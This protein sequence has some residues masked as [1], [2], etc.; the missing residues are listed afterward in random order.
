MTVLSAQRRQ[1]SNLTSVLADTTEHRTSLA[2]LT[3]RRHPTIRYEDHPVPTW[4]FLPDH[5]DRLS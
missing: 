4:P 5:R 2:R 1:G 3:R